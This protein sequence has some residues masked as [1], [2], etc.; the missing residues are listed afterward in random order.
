MCEVCGLAQG[1]YG[2]GLEGTQCVDELGVLHGWEGQRQRLLECAL[3]ASR[4]FGSVLDTQFVRSE[5]VRDESG[6]RMCKW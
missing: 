3:V 4:S 5:C 1:V 6:L 2:E